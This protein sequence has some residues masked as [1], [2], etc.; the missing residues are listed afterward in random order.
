MGFRGAYAKVE[1][2]DGRIRPTAPTGEKGTI[3]QFRPN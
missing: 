3:A 1:D 2:G